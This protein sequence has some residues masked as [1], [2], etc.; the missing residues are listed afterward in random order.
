MKWMGGQSQAAYMPIPAAP[1]V[2]VS[3]QGTGVS[4]T[5]IV[6]V[7]ANEEVEADNRPEALRL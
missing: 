3:T 6:V 5:V 7:C 4:S 2:T 1:L